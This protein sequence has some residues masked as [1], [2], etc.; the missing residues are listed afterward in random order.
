MVAPGGNACREGRGRSLVLCCSKSAFMV[1]RRGPMWL[2]FRAGTGNRTRAISRAAGG[3]CM[4]PLKCVFRLQML[5]AARFPMPARQPQ[6]CVCGSVARRG[7]LRLCAHLRRANILPDAG[8]ESIFGVMW[9]RVFMSALRPRRRGT[10]IT[11]P[12]RLAV[13]NAHG[14][15]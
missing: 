13:F 4:S 5:V 15:N 3:W 9:F 14:V 1:P 2:T 8:M 10:A 7:L 11:K 12:P 6:T